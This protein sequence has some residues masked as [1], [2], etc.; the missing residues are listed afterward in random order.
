MKRARPRGKLESRNP[1]LQFSEDVDRM[2]GM[3]DQEIL[4][5]RMT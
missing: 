4:A 5:N 2:I 3:V 1:W